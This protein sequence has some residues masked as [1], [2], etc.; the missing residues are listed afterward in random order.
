MILS[1]T[2]LQDLYPSGIQSEQHGCFYFLDY[3][4][5][6]GYFIQYENGQYESET[7]Y[8]DFD[9]LADDER[10]ECEAVASL[11]SRR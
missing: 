10:Q 11:I 4:N 5:E 3:D 9:T 2:E 7:Q 6:L 1:L 8:V